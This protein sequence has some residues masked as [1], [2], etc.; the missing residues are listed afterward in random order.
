[1]ESVFLFN[2][3]ILKN[4]NSNLNKFF[5][6]KESNSFLKD[7]FIIKK[8]FY[9]KIYIYFKKYRYLFQEM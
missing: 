6:Y 8:T 3:N 7:S 5:L 9:I 2:K 1:M 4:V